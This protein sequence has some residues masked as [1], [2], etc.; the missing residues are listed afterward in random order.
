MLASGLSRQSHGYIPPRLCSCQMVHTV[1]KGDLKGLSC[2]ASSIRAVLMRS[3]GVTA[4]MLAT[5][6][7][8]IPAI[9]L[10]RGGRVPVSGSANAFL[11]VS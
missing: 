8:V 4:V 1:F 11:I 5:T 2:L 6:P 9:M 3:V 7:A 10:R